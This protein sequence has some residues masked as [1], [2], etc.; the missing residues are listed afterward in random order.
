MSLSHLRIAPYAYKYTTSLSFS[1]S[2]YRYFSSFPHGT[3]SLS[4]IHVYLGFVGDSTIFT[5]N[6]TTYHTTFYTYLLARA[7]HTQGY[8]LLWLRD[9]LSLLLCYAYAIYSATLAYSPVSLTTTHGISL[10][11]FHRVS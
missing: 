9:S 3:C 10:V 7:N 6:Y 11:S 5:R 4:V 8:Y 2:F 1:H